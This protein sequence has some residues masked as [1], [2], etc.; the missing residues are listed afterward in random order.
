MEAIHSI[1]DWL[2]AGSILNLS[3]T[4][5]QL[6]HYCVGA[7]RKWRSLIAVDFDVHLNMRG[8]F[9]TYGELYR[10]L[11]CSRILT[12]SYIYGRHFSKIPIGNIPPWL[13]VFLLL[14]RSPP[15]MKYGRHR[16][17]HNIKGR[18]F[19]RL[20][21]ISL[22]QVRKVFVKDDFFELLGIPPLDPKKGRIHFSWR[23]VK[24]AQARKYGSHEKY[25]KYLID[26][27]HRARGFV[28]RHYEEVLG[29][30]PLKPL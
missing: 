4:C 17:K 20:S 3:E 10:L 27:C 12:A 15:V 21:S 30:D 7:Q 24:V 23:T 5:R 26:R 19:R 11:Y 25:E 8:K 14:S 1:I 28:T 16:I 2:D 18:Y 29:T 6:Y 13:C 22:S 9:K